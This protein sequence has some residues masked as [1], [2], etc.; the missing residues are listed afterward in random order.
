MVDLAVQSGMPG[1]TL[2]HELGE[3]TH[4]VRLFPFLGDVAEDAFPLGTAFPVRDHLPLVGIDI[5]LGDSVTLQLPGIQYMQVLHAM[6]GKFREGRHGL[7][8]GPP[9]ADDQLVLA[10]ID[11]LPLADLQEVQGTQDRDRILPVILL[12]ET[13]LDQ[14]PLDGEGRLGLEGLPTQTFDTVVHLEIVR[15]YGRDGI[16]YA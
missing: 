2:L 4:L 13:G 12:I 7:G 6:A 14:G 9:L 10:D 8:A 11:R 1:G 5:F 16:M 15:S 3:H